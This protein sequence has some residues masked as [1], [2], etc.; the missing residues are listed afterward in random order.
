MHLFRECLASDQNVKLNCGFCSFETQDTTKP[1]LQKNMSTHLLNLYSAL[2]GVLYL[3]QNIIQKPQGLFIVF[4]HIKTSSY[5]PAPLRTSK[6]GVHSCLSAIQ[7]LSIIKCPCSAERKLVQKEMPSLHLC[8]NAVSCDD[9]QLCKACME[10][11]MEA[12]SAVGGFSE[13]SPQSCQGDFRA[14]TLLSVGRKGAAVSPDRTGLN[15]T[16]FLSVKFS[17]LLL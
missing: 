16:C 17:F 13:E 2:A 15:P 6:P 3:K 10:K 14:S 4:H 11:A 9:C 5:C 8:H 1:Q 12:A 7:P